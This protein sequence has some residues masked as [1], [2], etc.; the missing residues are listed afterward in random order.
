MN[1]MDSAQ[2]GKSE[3]DPGYL[4]SIVCEGGEQVCIH[5]DE[6]GLKHLA[7]SLDRLLASLQKGEC[8]HDHMFADDWAGDELT[9][10]MLAGERDAGCSQVK[11]LKICGWTAEWKNEYGL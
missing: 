7:R 2:P 6:A 3:M 10:T 9:S 1:H 8:P 5:A 4:L 11:H